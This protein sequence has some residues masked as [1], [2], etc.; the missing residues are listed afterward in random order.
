ML[1]PSVSYS[2]LYP[3][4][5]IYLFFLSP[6]TSAI[7]TLYLALYS[8]VL[9]PLYFCSSSISIA[10]SDLHPDLDVAIPPTTL[11]MASH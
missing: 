11:A 10:A 5:F 4:T 9:P 3:S 8:D 1:T 6:A 2:T 7:L